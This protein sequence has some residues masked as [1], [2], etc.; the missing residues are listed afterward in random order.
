M[1]NTR[2]WN[3]EP[4][5]NA[6]FEKQLRGLIGREDPGARF[7]EKV[8]ALMKA[9]TT[10]QPRARGRFIVIG[11]AAMALA[12]AAMLGSYLRNAESTGLTEL[13][14][15]SAP[16]L[17]G[18]DLPA[19]A[20]PPPGAD[21]PSN[22]ALPELAET[23]AKQGLDPHTVVVLKRPEAAA[24]PR[25]TAFA[26]RCHDIFLGE[27]RVLGGLNVFTDPAV[28]TIASIDEMFA[29][30]ERDKKLA[31]A[32]GAGNALVITTL[33]G[34]RVALFSSQTGEYKPVRNVGGPPAEQLDYFAMDMAHRVRDAL[35]IDSKTEFDQAKAAIL[36][37]TLTDRE[38]VFALQRSANSLMEQG[39]RLKAVPELFDKDVVAAMVWLGT[40]S[41][42]VDVRS[43]ALGISGQFEIDDPALVQALLLSL[44]GDPADVVR[45]TVASTLNR[46]LDKPGVLAGLQRAAAEDPDG[47]PKDDC[48]IP[49]VREVAQRASIASKDFR[50][51][52]RDTLFDESLPPRSRLLN[53]TG[54]SP[55]GLAQSDPAAAR[56]VF[57]I[58]RLEQNPRVRAMAWDSLR[59]AAPDDAFVPVLIGDLTG[60]PDE[61]V[62]TL[63][64]QVLERYADNPDVRAAFEQALND[65]SLEVRRI[66]V[67]MTL[68]PGS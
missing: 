34:C 63:A 39:R 16:A 17:P 32:L 15:A 6:E 54:G 18:R 49:T 36:N 4:E 45:R 23:A 42:Y 26:A 50:Q 10:S 56:V 52:A 48:C 22:N 20:Q 27:L 51:W 68:H 5:P 12:A 38:R 29:L 66:A 67:H 65:Q 60:H 58:G 28:H 11:V 35:L 2:G 13:S 62:R 64:A 47:E 14:R 19:D 41:P 8:L 30:P 57:D 1:R 33:N 55:T 59:G 43:T 24:N 53:V 3:V 25:E 37:T 9:R 61:E 44:A 21:L 40:K 46:Y 31:R 7:T